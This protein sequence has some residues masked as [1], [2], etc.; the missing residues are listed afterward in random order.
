M[1]KTTR[2]AFYSAVAAAMF[3]YKRYP[4]HDDF[5]SVA[6]QI[7]AKYPF[8]GP[9]SFG[10]SHVS[11]IVF[12]HSFIHASILVVFLSMNSNVNVHLVLNVHVIA[13]VL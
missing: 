13:S 8:I 11:R 12:A 7:I 9:T 4:S 3:Q 10:A 5:I 1:T 6:R 2:A